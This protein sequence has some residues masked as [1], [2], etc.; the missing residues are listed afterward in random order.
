MKYQA[1]KN[2]FIE[3]PPGGFLFSKPG[4]H[5]WNGVT[6][7]YWLEKQILYTNIIY[8]HTMDG[9]TCLSLFFFLLHIDVPS[10]RCLLRRTRGVD[11]ESPEKNI[12]NRPPKTGHRHHRHL[13]DRDAECMRL[14]WGDEVLQPTDFP[15][16]KAEHLAGQIGGHLL[17]Q[18]LN[19]YQCRYGISTYIYS[20]TTQM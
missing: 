16:K 18:M 3:I 13:F 10:I 6:W 20:K 12:K 17:S 2:S 8:Q 7:H 1:S 9:N 19:V 5:G 14:I 4:F 11:V 15:R